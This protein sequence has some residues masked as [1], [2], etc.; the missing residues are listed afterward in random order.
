MPQSRNSSA[1]GRPLHLRSGIAHYPSREVSPKL[2]RCSLTAALSDA[3]D[4]AM[5]MLTGRG[6]PWAHRHPLLRR[7]N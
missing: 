2:E 5:A 6:A 7:K 4:L 3:R 1:T